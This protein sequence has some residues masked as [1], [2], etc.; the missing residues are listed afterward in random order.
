MTYATSTLSALLVFKPRACAMTNA[1][2]SAER[3]LM[4]HRES[5]GYL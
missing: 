3:G 2:A 5:S 4:V 1:A